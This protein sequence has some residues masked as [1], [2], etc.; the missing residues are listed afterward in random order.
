MKRFIIWVVCIILVGLGYQTAKAQDIK[1]EGKTFVTSSSHGAS[2]S[3]D[4]P[5]TYN[6]KDT[7]GNEYPIVLHQYTKGE[8]AGKWTAY[9]MKTSAKTGKE[10]KYYIPNGI[11]IASEIMKEMG[12]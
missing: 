12:I 8:N 1:R 3:K 2:A 6:W 5:T 9:V 10:Y 7:K 11:Q 4:I